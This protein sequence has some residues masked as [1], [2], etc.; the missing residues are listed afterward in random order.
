ME[1]EDIVFYKYTGKKQQTDWEEVRKTV[2]KFTGDDA[3]DLAMKYRNEEV[4]E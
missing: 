1:P 2:K 3:Y 4:P